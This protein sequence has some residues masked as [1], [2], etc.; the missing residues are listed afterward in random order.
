MHDL[1]LKYEAEGRP[2]EEVL[3]PGLAKVDRVLGWLRRDAIRQ[4]PDAQALRD[5]TQTPP[6]SQVR[7][8]RAALSPAAPAG[9]PA[10]PAP[11][12]SPVP[13]EA[14]LDR[15]SG[16]EGSARASGRGWA[17]LAAEMDELYEELVSGRAPD[18]HARPG[19]LYRP[20]QVEEMA[21]LARQWTQQVFGRLSREIPRLVWAE[22]GQPGNLFDAFAYQEWSFEAM[23]NVLRRDE[24]RWWLVNQLGH[25]GPASV[26]LR[27]HHAYPSFDRA[28]SPAKRG[29]PHHRSGDRRPGGRPGCRHADP[30]IHR[31]WYGLAIKEERKIL[32]RMFRE[33]VRQRDNQWNLRDMFQT[34]I[35][36]I[37]HHVEAPEYTD[38]VSSLPG[39]HARNTAE[40]GGSLGDDRVG[41]RS[42]AGA[43]V[44]R[45]T[46]P[47]PRSRRGR[48]RIRQRGSAAGRR[49]VRIRP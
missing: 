13:P 32:L 4:I 23:N 39:E 20:E 49:D 29:D 41:A 44:W 16:P 31:G 22:P 47:R 18:E 40:E 7:L 10:P 2:D 35:H 8:L 26:A 14:F 38:F 12:S 9:P 42:R 27:E 33:S 37:Q 1:A 6:A 34:I 25:G 45:R 19:A 3:D 28:S 5:L 21:G 43:D 30:G 48:R 46:L 11:P 36:E 15:L 17:A 24:A